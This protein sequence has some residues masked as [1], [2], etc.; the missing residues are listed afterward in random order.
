MLFLVF[1]GFSRNVR[2]EELYS[3]VV[4]FTNDPKLRRA[5]PQG[6]SKSSSSARRTVCTTAWL[7][8][9]ILA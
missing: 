7:D 2:V 3:F 1:N 5:F 9:S 8:P 6:R 4:C